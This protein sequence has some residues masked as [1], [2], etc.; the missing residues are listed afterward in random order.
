MLQ[1]L[2]ESEA[3]SS[4]AQHDIGVETERDVNASP[5]AAA[6]TK[7]E[8]QRQ[9]PAT[10]PGFER[11]QHQRLAAEAA[12]GR[13]Q[14]QRRFVEQQAAEAVAAAERER[15]QRLATEAAVGREQEQRR[16]VEQQAAEAVAAFEREQLQR[17]FVQQQ[18]AQA[19]ASFERERL[20]GND[21]LRNCTLILEYCGDLSLLD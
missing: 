13:E 14:E 10:E 12:V 8:W 19:V 16:F 21:R 9:W 15:Q 20:A 1:S 4:S 17:L 11:V 5:A 7:L 18:A 6:E 2:I 3:T